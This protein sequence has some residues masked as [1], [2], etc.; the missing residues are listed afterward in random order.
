MFTSAFTRATLYSLAFAALAAPCAVTTPIFAQ[1]TV[2]ASAPPKQHPG[3]NAAQPP[4]KSLANPNAPMLPV[5]FAG[6]LL[7][8]PAQSVNTPA[9]ADAANSAALAE[10]GLARAELANYSRGSE[11][12]NLRALRFTDS[13]GAYGAYTFYRQ[14]GWPRE[15]IGTGAA[16]DHNRVLFWQGNLV[17]DAN[18]S[19]ISAMTA[20]DLRELASD[21]AHP[22]ATGTSSLAPPI[23][24]NLPEIQPRDQVKLDP[25]TT[26]YA[27]GPAGYA[28]SG[29]VLPPTLVGFDHGAEAV[30]ATYSLRSGPATLSLINYPTPQI[31]A[32]QEKLI[33]AYLHSGNPQSLTKPLQDSNPAAIEVKRSGPLVALVSGDAIRDESHRLLA[34]VHYD[35][36]ISAIPGSG[37]PTEVQKT[38]RLLLGIMSL[39]AVMFAASLLLALFLGGGRALYRVACGKPASTIFDEEFTRLDLK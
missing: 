3:V 30:T 8:A 12:L 4:A 32:A 19:H 13:S 15:Q 27:L 33:T 39:V 5:D 23:L 24:G 20:A 31:A 25:Q 37:G 17:I 2:T 21:L 16:S 10:Y 18:F 34:L 35:A 36:D 28:G 38:A 6:W 7:K 11:T 29:G 26:H 9:M 1:I 22:V 14:S